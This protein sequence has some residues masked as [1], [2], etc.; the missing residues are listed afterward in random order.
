MDYFSREHNFLLIYA[1]L[2]KQLGHKSRTSICRKYMVL[3]KSGDHKM[4]N[5]NPQLKMWINFH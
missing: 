5:S 1:F 2:E 4:W 3:T